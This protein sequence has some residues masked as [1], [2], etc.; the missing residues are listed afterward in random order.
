MHPLKIFSFLNFLVHFYLNFKIYNIK[1]KEEIRA[2]SLELANHKASSDLFKA[3]LDEMQLNCNNDQQ[4]ARYML[5]HFHHHSPSPSLDTWTS[6]DQQIK[7]SKSLLDHRHSS[8]FAIFLTRP[9]LA[10]SKTCSTLE[11]YS[12]AASLRFV[13]VALH[14]RLTFIPSVIPSLSTTISTTTFPG[15]SEILTA[16]LNLFTGCSR[17]SRW[18]AAKVGYLWIESEQG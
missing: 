6:L 15:F 17:W 5:D 11:K 10:L 1:A 16:Y 14:I 13:I 12:E 8:S 9:F 3:Q 4:Q 7:S 18:I 2:M